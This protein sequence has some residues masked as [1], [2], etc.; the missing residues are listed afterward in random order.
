MGEGMRFALGDRVR[1]SPEYTWAQGATGTIAMPPD[2]VVDLVKDEWPWKSH[3]RYVKGVKGPIELYWVEF[4]H[5]QI[6]GD[7]D[8]PYRAGEIEADMI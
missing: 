2:F 1:I 6:D 3:H 4:D 8:G 5:P 7:G